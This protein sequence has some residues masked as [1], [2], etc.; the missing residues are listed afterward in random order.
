MEDAF[1]LVIKLD[2]FDSNVDDILERL[3]AAG[4]TDALVG[5]GVVGRWA[6]GLSRQAV[7]KGYAIRI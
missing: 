7:S 5:I 6:L 4:C 1:T 2:P 3:L